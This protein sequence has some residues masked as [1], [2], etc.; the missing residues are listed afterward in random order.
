MRQRGIPD[1]ITAIEALE[2]ARVLE[3][4]GVSFF[5]E[6]LSY[7]DPAGY[8]WLRQRAGVRIAG[9]ESLEGLDG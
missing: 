1:P 8:A 6:P 4:F 5:E 3:R 7:L 9:G 2:L